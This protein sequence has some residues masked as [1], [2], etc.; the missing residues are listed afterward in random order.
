[1]VADMPW[2]ILRPWPRSR[3]VV[4]TRV[5]VVQVDVCVPSVH[6]TEDPHALTR[7]AHECVVVARIPRHRRSVGSYQPHWSTGCT[8]ATAVVGAPRTYDACAVVGRYPRP[9]ILVVL[10][11]H[12][13]HEHPTPAAV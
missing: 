5:A 4:E 9:S 11:P 7:V 2:L 13:G 12:Q 6:R 3:L 1:M 10:A 8:I